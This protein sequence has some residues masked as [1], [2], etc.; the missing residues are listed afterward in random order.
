MDNSRKLNI[1]KEKHEIN[2]DYLVFT[3]DLKND[4][5]LVYVG[6]CQEYFKN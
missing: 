5:G 1:D 6:T 2:K 3:L 4:K